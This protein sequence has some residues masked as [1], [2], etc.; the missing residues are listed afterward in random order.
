LPAPESRW[1][2]PES[3]GRGKTN[4]SWQ[5]LDPSAVEHAF[6][7][8]IAS[9]RRAFHLIHWRTAGAKHI[10][11]TDLSSNLHA[12]PQ[13]ALQPSTTNAGC[14]SSGQAVCLARLCTSSHPRKTNCHPR[15][16]RLRR[17]SPPLQGNISSSGSMLQCQLLC[18]PTWVPGCPT[19]FRACPSRR[20][21]CT[22]D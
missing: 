8:S 2:K 3:A 17:L 14:G 22:S 18:L 6:P 7:P 4:G 1:A 13:S 16:P 9:S 19:T 11:T 20:V 10:A 21:L 15:A 5:V 12:R